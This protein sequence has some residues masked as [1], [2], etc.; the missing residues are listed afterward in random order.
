MRVELVFAPGC[1]NYRKAQGILEA[2]IAEERLPIS[3]EMVEERDRVN[4][5]PAVRIDGKEIN[6]ALFPHHFE[7]LCSVITH[8]W[9]ELTEKQLRHP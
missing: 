4:G 8:Y 6:H 2:V 9:K 3:V 5:L 7:Q 1:T